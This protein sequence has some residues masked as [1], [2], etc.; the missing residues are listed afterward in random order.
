MAVTL[1]ALLGG[2]LLGQTV[3]ILTSAPPLRRY[4][5]YAS[6]AAWPNARPGPADAIVYK[7]RGL[8]DDDEYYRIMKGYGYEE[9][10]ADELYTASRR[11]V[12]AGE[13]ITLYRRGEITEAT[14]ISLMKEVGFE[15]REQAILLKAT[16]FYPSPQDLI[17]WQAREV[18]EPKMIEKYGLDDEYE[19]I[20]KAAFY[21]AGMD[22]EQIRNY[23]MAHWQ[24]P[25]WTVVREMLHR[26]DLT[27][28]DVYE[29]FKLVEIPPYWREKYTKIMY[30]PYTRVDVRRMYAAGIL[31]YDGVL[32]AY[33]ELGY[34]EEKA[35]N[36]ADFAV[37]TTLK[38]ERDL[39]RAQIEK[40]FEEA[41]LDRSTAMLLLQEMGY[42][43]LEADYIL[44]LKEIALG[45]DVQK[46]EI[47]TLTDMYVL[48]AVDQETLVAGFD[49][50][51]LQAAYRDTLVAKA[52]RLKAAKV[53]M[54]TLADLQTFR[55]QKIIDEG[56]FVGMMGE[57]GYRS[58][59]IERYL[60]VKKG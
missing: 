56:T 47:D 4:F 15:D 5:E 29:W 46:Y 7:R 2:M 18:F 30:T 37:T 24:H 27:E 53:R 20:E 39:T 35:R 45:D 11:V 13:L 38:P 12:D 55:L 57:L 9:A 34:T 44:T 33:K 28:E 3:N 51:N 43:E 31:D 32:E 23:W 52:L 14:F 16:M 59:D 36:L 42:D 8:I 25:G 50:M 60:K 58:A 1:T 21:K 10:R 48:G 6:N 54:P 22:D 17:V 19:L 40:G 26:T 49:S 41:I